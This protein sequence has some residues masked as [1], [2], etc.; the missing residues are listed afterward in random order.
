MAK[1]RAVTMRGWSRGRVWSPKAP[2]NNAYIVMATKINPPAH[3]SNEILHGINRAAVLGF[4]QKKRDGGGRTQLLPSARK[5]QQADEAF[6]TISQRLCQTVFEIDGGGLLGD[7][8]PGRVAP[9]LREI[10]LEEMR[11]AAV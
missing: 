8:T 1:K 5:A 10:Y 11:K 3:L 6:T 2:A 9:R 7:G 4:W